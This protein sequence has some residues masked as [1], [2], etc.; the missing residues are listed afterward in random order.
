MMILFVKV[1]GVLF[2]E[3]AKARI[4][5]PYNKLEE[6]Q[7]LELM[8]SVCKDDEKPGEWLRRIDIA[9]KREKDSRYLS[10]VYPGGLSKCEAECATL[11]ASCSKLLEDEID[12]D[13]LSGALWKG[14]LKLADAQVDDKLTDINC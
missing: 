1:V 10:L 2:N 9:E 12:R 13:E 3:T 8:D 6:I 11:S 5:A 7:I 14:S 4:S